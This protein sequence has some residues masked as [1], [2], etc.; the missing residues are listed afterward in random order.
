MAW[1][2]LGVQIPQRPLLLFIQQSSLWI[3][4]FLRGGVK[5][6]QKTQSGGMHVKQIRKIGKFGYVGQGCEGI[7]SLGFVTVRSKNGR[8]R[9]VMGTIKDFF[10]SRETTKGN[11]PWANPSKHFRVVE[12]L[13]Q[14]NQKYKL[15]LRLPTT[16][17]LVS[18]SRGKK[19]GL[20]TNYVWQMH[21]ISE[22]Y[23]S[24]A[25]DDFR[26]QEDTLRKLGYNDVVE[27][28][29]QVDP[30]TNRGIAVLIDFGHLK[31]TK[32]ETTRR[33]IERR[34]KRLAREISRR[35]E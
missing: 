22:P 12:F 21:P 23:Y 34:A 4:P 17:R 35:N 9:E 14:L 16:I 3:M 33:D 18:Y 8:E 7:T 11:D 19:R 10:Y 29:F 15:G 2:R 13:K 30:K 28:H 24:Q 1:K 26:R 25:R 27:C 32:K 6:R 31:T 5:H 20:F